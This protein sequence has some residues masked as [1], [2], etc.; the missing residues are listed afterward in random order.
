[1]IFSCLFDGSFSGRQIAL[2]HPFFGWTK[3]WMHAS[4]VR[5]DDLL[6][7]GSKSCK[8]WTCQA[9][10]A[11]KISQNDST[12]VSCWNHRCHR[13]PF[14]TGWLEG[15][16]RSSTNILDILRHSLVGGLEHF[17]FFHILGI[18][19]QLTFIFCKMVKTTNQFLDILFIWVHQP[20][21]LNIPSS[22]WS[23]SFT[24]VRWNRWDP[25]TLNEKRLQKNERGLYI[26]SGN[27]I[28]NIGRSFFLG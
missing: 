3:F 23:R 17:L 9:Y 14:P 16:P 2:S 12:I 1:M 15:S 6:N 24:T 18:S 25:P 27:F 11:L 26:A 10:Q 19:S 13:C 5:K 4:A 7:R 20:R 28:K 8:S 22:A 21:S